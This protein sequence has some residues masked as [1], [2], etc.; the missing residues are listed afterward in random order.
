MALRT[1]IGVSVCMVG[2][3]RSGF[4]NVAAC[5]VM[6]AAAA[7]TAVNTSLDS[8]TGGLGMT[9]I[10]FCLVGELTVMVGAIIVVARTA[11][12]CMTVN[13]ETTALTVG[14]VVYLA[15]CTAKQ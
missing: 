3:A 6:A 1:G 4:H 12:R 9:E 13:T 8:S 2:S 10:T 5:R 15:L 7:Y 14:L 11:V